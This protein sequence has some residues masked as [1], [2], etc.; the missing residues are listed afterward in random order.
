M[1]YLKYIQCKGRAEQNGANKLPHS[2]TMG[3]KKWSFEQTNVYV[4]FG[5]GLSA[6]KM[7]NVGL[8]N[9]QWSI[10]LCIAAWIF[11]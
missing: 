6:N 8:S 3:T 4:C 5:Y 10:H 7:Q 11:I 2:L 9:R 1:E